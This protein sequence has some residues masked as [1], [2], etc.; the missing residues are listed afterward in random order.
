MTAQATAYIT[1]SE[2]PDH[3][4]SNDDDSGLSAMARV[5]VLRV[6]VPVI[7]ITVMLLTTSTRTKF[8][9]CDCQCMIVERSS[10]LHASSQE[11]EFKQIWKG[12]AA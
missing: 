7:M 12:P 3:H 11:P 10:S 8:N 9:L 2:S 6:Q 1:E 4:T 5:P